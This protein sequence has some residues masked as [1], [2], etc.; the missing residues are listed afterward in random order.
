MKEFI[1]VMAAI[2][3]MI[4]LFTY[5]TVMMDIFVA[6]FAIAFVLP[7]AIGVGGVIKENKQTKDTL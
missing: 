7:F 6:G 1:I 2:I 4:L 5:P 3:A